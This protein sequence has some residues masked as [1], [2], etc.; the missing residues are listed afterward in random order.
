MRPDAIQAFDDRNRKRIAGA[1]AEGARG[2]RLARGFQQ[3]RYELPRSLSHAIAARHPTSGR[4]LLHSTALLLYALYQRDSEPPTKQGC[5]RVAGKTRAFYAKALGL[6]M[7]REQR[8]DGRA[9]E[10]HGARMVRVYDAE[11]RA[12]GLIEHGGFYDAGDGAIYL[13]GGKIPLKRRV[14]WI[15]PA[16]QTIYAR[17]VAALAAEQPEEA[18]Q[19]VGATRRLVG[20]AVDGNLFP[21][22]LEIALAISES[23][24]DRGGSGGSIGAGASAGEILPVDDSTVCATSALVGAPV[25]SVGDTSHLT[26]RPTSDKMQSDKIV[27]DGKKSSGDDQ[28]AGDGDSEP[29]SD[30]DGEPPSLEGLRASAAPTPAEILAAFG[31]STVA[32]KVLEG[33]ALRTALLAD[34]ATPDEPTPPTVRHARRPHPRPCACESCVAWA[35]AVVSGGKGHKP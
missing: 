13:R 7:K 23:V 18:Q 14:T 8:T 10:V 3:M 27:T 2:R 22:D 16:A 17:Y 12:A 5:R 25:V 1:L 31:L 35:R 32:L 19:L 33:P 24:L 15:P 30:S 21:A 29:P 11:L 6:S 26:G 9:G 20:P 4:R 28:D 34:L